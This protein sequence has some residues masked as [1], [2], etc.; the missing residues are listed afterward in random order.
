MNGSPEKKV[1]ENKL[2]QNQSLN[3]SGRFNINKENV[4]KTTPFP[5]RKVPTSPNLSK[6]PPNQ[7]LRL[8]CMP[9]K[10]TCSLQDEEDQ[11]IKFISDPRIKGKIFELLHR[12]H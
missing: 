11:L 7:A 9:L 1:L 4:F 6:K 2:L 10:R 8:T 12:R 3:F 5:N